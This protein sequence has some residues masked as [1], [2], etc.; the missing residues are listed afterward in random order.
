[1]YIMFVVYVVG[2]KLIA[3]GGLLDDIIQKREGG[4][5]IPNSPQL[6]LTNWQ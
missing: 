2:D 4:P 1:M 5:D 3:Q 6:P